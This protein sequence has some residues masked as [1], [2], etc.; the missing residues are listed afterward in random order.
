MTGDD[1]QEEVMLPAS[2]TVND[3][4]SSTCKLI[5]Y[6]SLVDT[7]ERSCVCSKCKSSLK[8]SETTIGIATTIFLTCA[9]CHKSDRTIIARP[10]LTD[11]AKAASANPQ[12][13]HRYVFSDFPINYGLVFLM[14]QLGMSLEGLRVVLGHLGLATS[15]GGRE[16]WKVVT[17]NI[18]TAQHALSK[19]CILNNRESEA[20]SAKTNGWPSVMDTKNNVLR[21]GIGVSADAGWQKRASGRSYNSLSGH[22]LM[23]GCLTRKVVARNVYSKVCRL[24]DLQ[25]RK[26]NEHEGD[27]QESTTNQLKPHRCPKNFSGSAKAMEAASAV[28]CCLSMYE[29]TT[30]STT[31]VFLHTVV[32]DDDST[33]KANLRINLEEKLAAINADRQRSNQ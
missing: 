3:S 32:M 16:K 8:V 1:E 25:S 14:Q 4:L 18:G 22:F 20:T 30:T 29:E 5:H 28:T 13:K 11:K 21:Q 33:T 2:T 24:C 23:I 7:I 19:Q 17:D 27:S 10:P 31:P 12:D 15:V 9:N 6:A 26:D